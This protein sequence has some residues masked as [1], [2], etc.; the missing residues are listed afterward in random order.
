MSSAFPDRGRRQ[1]SRPFDSLKV[2]RDLLQS[3]LTDDESLFPVVHY[4]SDS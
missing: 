3:H 4:D 1:L 2:L